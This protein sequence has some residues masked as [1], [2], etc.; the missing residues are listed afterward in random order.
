MPFFIG[1][2]ADRAE[3]RLIDTPRRRARP[4]RPRDKRVGGCRVEARI[5]VSTAGLK[6]DQSPRE[7]P[8]KAALDMP[9]IARDSHK[10]QR[11]EAAAPALRPVSYGNMCGGKTACGSIRRKRWD[12]LAR[13]E[14]SEGLQTPGVLSARNKADQDRAGIKP[15]RG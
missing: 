10:G 3:P 11:P 12:T 6:R 14:G 1:G 9:S 13:G 5:K 8:A 4:D 7:Q 2:R 15:P